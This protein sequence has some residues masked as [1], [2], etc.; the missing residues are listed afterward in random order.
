MSNRLQDQKMAR[1]H[2][3]SNR[4]I[5]RH[6]NEM[7][8][9]TKQVQ[10]WKIRSEALLATLG[11]QVEIAIAESA[12]V[13]KLRAT[14]HDARRNCDRLAAQVAQFQNLQR[15]DAQIARLL[16][17]RNQAMQA[18]ESLRAENA[19]LANT[20]SEKQQCL[21]HSQQQVNKLQHSLE[22]RTVVRDLGRSD[23]SIQHLGRK[24]HWE[25]MQAKHGNVPSIAAVAGTRRDEDPEPK[26][27]SGTA[28]ELL[29]ATGSINVTNGNFANQASSSEE[30]I[31]RDRKRTHT[32]TQ[33]ATK[34]SAKNLGTEDNKDAGI[35]DDSRG[36]KH[37]RTSWARC[38]FAHLF[39]TLSFVIA[40][41]SLI[42]V[43]DSATVAVLNV[44]L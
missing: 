37:A 6:K 12:T 17:E 40:Q 18:C 43:C 22:R 8:A 38:P 30:P 33:D 7:D 32:Q 25:K 34:D 35:S 16:Q 44:T 24:G 41:L 15:Q 9:L 31:L 21:E 13:E 14:L 20:L 2:R 3:A 5:K 27:N 4:L 36:P 19:T 26:L 28:V 1:E 10:H 11:T 29:Q 42:D 39:H 23:T